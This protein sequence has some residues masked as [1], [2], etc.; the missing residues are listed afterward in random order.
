MITGG[1]VTGGSSRTLKKA[2]A[3]EVNSVHSWFSSLK[4]P[5]S[6]EPDIIFSE[7]DA[8]DIKQPHDGPVVK[9]LK[10]EEFNIHWVLVD[11]RSSADIIYL[12]PF[13]QMKLSQ[14]RLRP[15]TSPLVSFTGDRITP[16]GIIRLTAIASTY[17]SQISKEIDFLV[18]D[19]SSTYN[20]ILG[21]P[22]LN[23]LKVVTST[24][25]LKVKFPTAYGI[26][27]IQGD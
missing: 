18:V 2:Y 23:K 16:R 8:C 1:L 21:Q 19:Y 3:R 26:R 24:Y 27:E 12:L 15:F 13:Q 4:I 17:P 14:E 7:K 9:M 6:S 22:T 5:W 10:M 20:V 25:Y 11:N